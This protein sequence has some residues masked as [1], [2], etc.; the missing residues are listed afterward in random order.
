M[1]RSTL[2]R[3]AYIAPAFLLLIVTSG[4]TTA[5][6]QSQGSNAS[7]NQLLQ[8]LNRNLTRSTQR[9]TEATAELLVRIEASERQTLQLLSIAEENQLRLE[10]LQRNL[11]D[12]TATLYRHLNLTPRTGAP[13]FQ[14]PTQQ[15]PPPGSGIGNPNVTFQ[16]PGPPRQLDDPE[17]AEAERAAAEQ[18]HYTRAQDYYKSKEYLLALEEFGSFIETF[19]GAEH[20]DWAHYWRAMC[21]Y[22]LGEFQDAISGLETVQKNYP[23]SDKV[24]RSIHSQAVAY[25]RLG[26]NARAIELLRLL[27]DEYPNGVVTQRAR[28]DLKLLEEAQP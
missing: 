21:H 3:M 13:R 2:L 20:E 17:D 16:D 8:T 18:A 27:I 15:E 19:P 23:E 22:R 24:P 26:Q 12:L 7:T 25:S 14:G 28:E 5:G 11:D 1:T 9:M 10:N 4:C 6:G